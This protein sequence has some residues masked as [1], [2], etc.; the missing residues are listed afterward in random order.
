MCFRRLS[1][2]VY[3]I[4]N[5]NAASRESSTASILR[6]T[7]ES[8]VNHLERLAGERERIQ[9]ARLH[10]RHPRD[11]RAGEETPAGRVA[12]VIYQ[13]EVVFDTVV[14]IVQNPVEDFER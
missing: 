4:I 10:D 1:L 9:I 3:S 2:C 12:Y 11:I 8:C 6:C 5:A 14:R 7:P 13:H